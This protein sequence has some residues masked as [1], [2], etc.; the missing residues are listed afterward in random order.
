M[1]T[2]WRNRLKRTLWPLV[3]LAGLAVIVTYAP[4][5]YRSLQLENGEEIIG[6]RGPSHE[7]ITVTGGPPLAESKKPPNIPPGLTL[8]PA[9]LWSKSAKRMQAKAYPAVLG[10][11]IH[12]RDLDRNA[13]RD[14][15]LGSVDVFD[16]M[17]CADGSRIFVEYRFKNDESG[18]NEY[19]IG[20]F[21]GQTGKSLFSRTVSPYGPSS[22]SVTDNGKRL[23]CFDAPV[24]I[25]CVD[26]ETGRQVYACAGNDPVI[27][28]DGGYLAMGT[29][30]G[31]LEGAVVI[32]LKTGRKIHCRSDITT[33]MNISFSPHGDKVMYLPL[34]ANIYSYDMLDLRSR[35]VI[36]HAPHGSI[37]INEGKEVAAPT[38]HEGGL[39]LEFQDM[40]G[41]H[42]ELDT[43]VWME[44]LGDLEAVDRNGYLI[45]LD[46]REWPVQLTWLQR[47]LTW[48]G[49]KQTPPDEGR[50]QWLLFDVRSKKVLDRGG[51]E[52]VD[53]STDGRYAVSHEPGK[54]VLK[55]HELPLHRSRLFMLFGAAVWTILAVVARHWWQRRLKPLLEDAGEPVPASA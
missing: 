39:T 12:L 8:P 2:V 1:V 35:K 46:A 37:F 33:C 31:E 49:Q 3:W 52:L 48:L 17:P 15:A 53:A 16:V 25:A 40:D 34:L 51:D 43:I 11:A 5:G 30:Y 20:V 6:F 50:H 28:P 38:Y 42:E 9:Q 7:L 14:L 29:T 45:R 55:I 18:G 21:D 47:V 41:H 26:V 54:S 23:V 36:D 27:S 24:E 10:N 32:D 44:S 13:K 22:F 4:P 19:R